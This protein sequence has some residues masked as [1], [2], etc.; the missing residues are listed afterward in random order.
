MESKDVEL[1]RVIRDA[2]EK[3]VTVQ[4]G[5][6]RITR[7]L[8]QELVDALGAYNDHHGLRGRK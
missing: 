4:L 2:A 1:L 8:W 3:M 7:G 6:G 5:T